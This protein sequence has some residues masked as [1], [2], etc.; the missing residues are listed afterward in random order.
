[1]TSSPSLMKRREKMQMR[2]FQVSWSSTKTDRM[3]AL[4][5]HDCC[6]A[7]KRYELPRKLEYR[8]GIHFTHVIEVAREVTLGTDSI[9]EMRLSAIWQSRSASVSVPTNVVP[10]VNGISVEPE[11]ISDRPRLS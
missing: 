3:R 7:E 9:K 4:G 10:G 6:Y 1:M 5:S 11:S 2:G 8:G